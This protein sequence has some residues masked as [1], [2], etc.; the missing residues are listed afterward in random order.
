MTQKITL[1][2]CDS[3]P[4]FRLLTIALVLSTM[5]ASSVL[6]ATPASTVAPVPALAAQQDRIS[7]STISKDDGVYSDTQQRIKV[8]NDGGRRVADYQL[9]KAQCWLDVSFHEY[10]RNDRGNFPQA[11][12]GESQ[13]ILTALENKQDPGFVTPLVN[14]AEKLRPDLWTRQDTL[15]RHSGFQCATQQTA[16]AEVELVHAGNEFR[17]SGWR[18]AKPYIQIAEDLTGAAESAAEACRPMPVAAI[19]VVLPTPVSVPKKMTLSADALFRFDKSSSTDLLPKGIAELD[20][21]AQ[22]ITMGT[23]G[24]AALTVVG[25]TDRL[26]SIAYNQRL[27]LKRAD[28]VRYYLQ[29]KGVT[30]PIAVQG[31]GQD[32]PVIACDGVKPKSA[33]IECLAPNRRVEVLLQGK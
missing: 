32:N 2:S 21:M 29:N 18:H 1:A 23:T 15:R 31:R 25:Y 14:E 10:S 17:E 27:S 7:D 3:Q 19:P 9:S 6:A 5:M 22:Q 28:T 24:I 11:A 26:G 13:R 33:L 8:L 30:L 12:L 4:A 20:H 16:C